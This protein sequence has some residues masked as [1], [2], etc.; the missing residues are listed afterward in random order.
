M[1]GTRAGAVS[2]E[3]QD[4]DR[5]VREQGGATG[6]P[7]TMVS[8]LLAL[9][10]L[11]SALGMVNT[12]AVSVPERTREIGVLRALPALADPRPQSPALPHRR[13]AGRPSACRRRSGLRDG[14]RDELTY[15]SSSLCE[16][17][18]GS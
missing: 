10:V 3:V 16:Q 2:V 9:G 17:G 8:G 5:L 15:R 6:G 11:I 13:R 7:L 4:R 12:L 14:G 1:P 18:E